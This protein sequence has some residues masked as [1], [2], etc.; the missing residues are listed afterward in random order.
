MYLRSL[1]RRP[2]QSSASHLTSEGTI[3][4]AD[5]Q[6]S[7]DATA[8]A[9]E[10]PATEER[11]ES[12]IQQ[13]EDLKEEKKEMQENCQLLEYEVDSLRKERVE[14]R[15][16]LR[17]LLCH[18]LNLQIINANSTQVYQLSHCSFLSVNL[19]RTL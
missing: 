1:K 11:V 15:E 12:L 7:N 6:S 19:S 14:L 17:K 13:V 5:N 3:L 10:A 8:R 2:L 18:H 4:T 16:N 9:T